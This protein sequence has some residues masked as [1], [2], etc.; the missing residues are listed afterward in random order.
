MSTPRTSGFEP[1]APRERYEPPAR[2][3]ARIPVRDLLLGKGSRVWSVGPNE[4]AHDAVAIMA[5]AHVG[6][7][8]VLDHGKL[9]GIVSERD[10]VRK[11]LLAG[12]SARQT[13]ISEI[14]V[15]Q[16][17]T[18]G[19]ESSLQDCMQL[20]TEHRVR[21]LPVLLGERVAGMISIGDA[22]RA[23]LLQQSDALHEL[24]RYVSGEPRLKEPDGADA[25]PRA[26]RP[27]MR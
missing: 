8:V 20:M 12:R 14:M 2:I 6:A 7:L 22:V 17:V 13:L 23:T 5:S 15:T 19:Q 21:H 27:S 25:A 16:V 3:I 1:T 11:V 24:E 4:T 10:C 9:V 18:V 26:A